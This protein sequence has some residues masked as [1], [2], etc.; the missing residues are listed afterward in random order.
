MIAYYPPFDD[1][2]KSGPPGPPGIGFNLTNDGNY[3]MNNKILKNCE[4]P[5]D[6]KD[7]TTKIFVLDELAKNYETIMNIIDSN[8]NSFDDGFKS[9][10]KQTGE[11]V[12]SLDKDIRKY[13]KDHC[14]FSQDLNIFDAKD[15]RIGNIKDPI[16]GKNAVNRRYF[17]KNAITLKKNS[18]NSNIFDAGNKQISNVLDP[19]LD[20]DVVNKRYVDDKVILVSSIGKNYFD[21]L[22]FNKIKNYYFEDDLKLKFDMTMILTLFFK[23]DTNGQID[24]FFETV[25]DRKLC[26]IPNASEHNT[27]SCSTV[28]E[29]KINDTITIQIKGGKDC[30]LK[31]EIL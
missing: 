18:D 29:G 26:Q 3:D 12:Q 22:S 5:I 15:R 24:V 21:Y 16:E 14:L 6:E 31:I 30:F 8:R 17:E 28:L 25:T 11:I 9:F 4:N 27:Y 19:V 1:E 10:V 20:T 2:I 7:V 23:S 13:M